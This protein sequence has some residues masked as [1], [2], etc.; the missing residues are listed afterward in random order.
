MP[1]VPADWDTANVVMSMR[2]FK[3]TLPQMAFAIGGLGLAVAIFKGMPGPWPVRAIVALIPAGIG[4]SM[5]IVVIRDKPL[6]NWLTVALGY[7]RQPRRKVWKRVLHDQTGSVKMFGGKKKNAEEGGTAQSLL[8]VKTI[9]NNMLVLNDG[10]Y[11]AILRVSGIN[12]ALLAREEQRRVYEDFKAFLNSL[13]FP[14]QILVRLRRQDIDTYLEFLADRVTE[15][16]DGQLK[17][18]ALSYGEWVETRVESA[19]LMS[20]DRY[21]IISWAP[22]MIDQGVKSLL[23]LGDMD[24]E[25]TDLDSITDQMGYRL[26]TVKSGLR[27]MGLN[28]ETL[29][30]EDL[31]NLLYESWNPKLSESQKPS[32]D[33][34][35]FAVRG[36]G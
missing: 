12:I 4:V 23:K 19:R 34:T 9:R 5:A 32:S 17:N 30:N 1:K 28:V 7:F 8:N 29:K 33:D 36:R 24:D 25:F 3:I 15:M 6:Y 26:D 22:R 21:V 2:G 13:K 18:Y 27:R 20:R 35:S 10:G 14:V 11:R 16:S 31:K